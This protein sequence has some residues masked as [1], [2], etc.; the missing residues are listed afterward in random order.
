MDT[1]VCT[2]ANYTRGCYTGESPWRGRGR[3]VGGSSVP[4]ER[5]APP[6]PLGRRASGPTV[7]PTHERP[8]KCPGSARDPLSVHTHTG[9]GTQSEREFL[10]RTW[11]PPASSAQ[12]Q[13][14]VG[15]GGA[16]QGSNGWPTS[17]GEEASLPELGGGVLG[18]EFGL[19]GGSSLPP[20][21]HRECLPQQPLPERGHLRGG[22]RGCWGLPV[23]VP[24]GLRRVPLRRDAA[25]RPAL[26]R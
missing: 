17:P 13:H 12:H 15:A 4:R 5:P 21:L 3:R 14:L 7:Q 11:G 24:G 26:L 22:G 18:A 6:L 9:G 10:Q 19:T 16:S 23:L 25:G 20:S 2:V 8:E 1:Q